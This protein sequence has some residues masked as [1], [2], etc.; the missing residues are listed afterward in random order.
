M[1]KKNIVENFSSTL[2]TIVLSFVIHRC[3]Y[4]KSSGQTFLD[5]YRGKLN[6][7]PFNQAYEICI[8]V[9]LSPI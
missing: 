9:P 8:V 4:P 7:H 6:Q 3:N 5:N 1:P 2:V